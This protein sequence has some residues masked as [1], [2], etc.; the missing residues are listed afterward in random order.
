MTIAAIILGFLVI[1]PVAIV[2]VGAVIVDR[3]YPDGR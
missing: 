2:G 3:L 1:L